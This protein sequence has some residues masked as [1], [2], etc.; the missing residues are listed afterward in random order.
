MESPKLKILHLEDNPN[1]AELIA[2]KLKNGGHDLDI[3]RVDS[4]KDFL[5][6]LDAGGFDLILADRTAPTFDG[7]MALKMAHQIQP[8]V[9]FVFVSG[10]LNEETAIET[11]TN[12]ATDYVLKHHLSRL[13]PAVNRAL[14]EVTSR[15]E[16]ERLEH[17]LMQAQKMESLGTLAGGIAHD[18][19]NVLGIILGYNSLLEDP[20]LSPEDT[21]NVSQNIRKATERGAALVRQLLTFARNSEVDFRNVDL[22]RLVEDLFGML[23]STFPKSIVFEKKLGA[24][25]PS[26]VADAG[27]IHQ[28]LL[29]L[30]VNARDAMSGGGKLTIE[31]GLVQDGN[32]EESSPPTLEQSHVYLKVSDTGCGMEK[33]VLQRIFDPFFT[34]KEKG[35]GT[36]LGLAVVYGVMQSHHGLIKVHSVRGQGTTFHLFFPIGEKKSEPAPPPKPGWRNIP[37]GTECILV[38]EDEEVLRDLLH[39]MLAFKGYKVFTAI[40]GNDGL[41]VFG[42]HRGE[43]D[44]VLADHGMPGVDGM[45]MLEIIQK[46]APGVKT[47]LC[48]GYVDPEARARMQEAGLSHFFPKPYD[49]AQILRKIREVFDAKSP[50]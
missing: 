47:I 3:R 26:I 15:R 37:G 22:N 31:T 23:Q 12:G 45:K 9:P 40:D 48:S 43:I 41:R 33:K 14:N 24:G 1:D 35:K 18:F 10:T 36:G 17:E 38:V 32:A 7:L 39:A 28:V 34:T 49:N 50:A 19:N 13:V 4:Q 29:N 5:D 2:L 20:S 8:D 16:K 6:S 42:Q 21:H 25:V 11:L 27:Q 30:C 46:E 44:M